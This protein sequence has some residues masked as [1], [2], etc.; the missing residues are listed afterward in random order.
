MELVYPSAS[1]AA[2]LMFGALGLEIVIEGAAHI[3]RTGPVVLASNH[4]SYLDFTLVGLA[5]RPRRVRR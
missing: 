1:W 5:A 3:P 2:R 4:V